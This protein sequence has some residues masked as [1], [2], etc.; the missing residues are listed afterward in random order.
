MTESITSKMFQSET[1][2]L[3]DSVCEQ[4]VTAIVIGEI[5]PGQKISEPELAKTYG[6]SRGPLREA[7]RKLEALRLVERKPHI[8]ARVVNLSAK[9]LI[10]IYRVREALEG[11]ACRLAAEN[12]PQD[13]ID[14]LRD[15][16]D[17]HEQSIDQLD[18]RSYFQ[19]EG[20]LDFHYRIVNGS[21]NAKLLEFLG[22]DLYHLVRMYRYQFSVS[23][24]RPKRALKEHRQIIDAIE[25][26]DPELAEMLMRRHIGAARK[27]VE[28]KLNAATESRGE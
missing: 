6:I 28:D 21:K 1:R 22:G 20:D 12:M 14:S 4:I 24:S 27:N 13:E 25:S 23:S 9:E 7:M 3:A 10:E 18:G 16:L 11:M 26:R 8:G 17:E 15:L 19:K 2:T 5:P